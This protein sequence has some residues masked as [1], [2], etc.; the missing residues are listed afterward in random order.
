MSVLAMF[1]C[2]FQ[3]TLVGGQVCYFLK[4]NELQEDLE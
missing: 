1:R 2:I 4:K 3:C